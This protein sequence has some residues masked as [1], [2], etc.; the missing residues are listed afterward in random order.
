[1]TRVLTEAG[2]EVLHRPMP[3]TMRF[4]KEGIWPYFRPHGCPM[5]VVMF[6]DVYST[7]RAQITAGRVKTEEEGI[8]RIHEAYHAIFQ[9]I[10]NLLWTPV[11]YESLGTDGVVERICERLGLD[12]SRV[13]SQWKDANAKY[14]GGEH[15]SDNSPLVLR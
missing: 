7:V 15:F 8:E 14:Y 12:S 2:G 4:A 6:R 3:M 5:F 13:M 9:Q 11:T 10:E 1:M